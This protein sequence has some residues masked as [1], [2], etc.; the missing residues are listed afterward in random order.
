MVYKL[1]EKTP[2]AKYGASDVAEDAARL[3]LQGVSGAAAAVPGFFGDAM[4]FV[5]SVLDIPIEHGFGLKPIPYEET[6]IGKLLPTT[7]KHKK[8][9]EEGIP[10]LKP[11]N[12]VEKFANEAA[13]DA[14]QLFLPG[15]LLRQ[16]KYAFSPLR[17]LGISLSA[18]M[19][20]E[21]TYQ[22]T[23]NK[24]LAD[25]VKN[26]AMLAFSLFN[27]TGAKDIVKG[28]YSKAE[29]LRPASASVSTG[30]LNSN[31]SSVTNR[32]LNGRQYNQLAPS[33][34][35]V[36]DEVNKVLQ[37][38]S[39]GTVPVSTLQ[40]I[41]TSLN[42][43]LSNTLYEVKDRKTRQGIKSTAK[44]INRF[45]RETLEEYGKQNPEWWKVYSSADKAH[46]AVEQS[47]FI[48]RS[49]EKFMKGRPESIAHLF[50]IGIPAGL[51]WFNPVGG[52]V[53]A[54]G[55]L[56]AKLGTRI[57][58]S[59]DLAKHYAKVAGAAASDNPKLITKE[60]DD[61]EEALEKEKKSK[62]KLKPNK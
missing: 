40:S 30:N 52:L 20:G 8:N 44:S 36:I 41:K 4:N 27:P 32:I 56:A 50:G 11:K 29:S 9:L 10:Y 14:V 58:K 2:E 26:G 21:G 45:L 48:S 57:M 18:N 28:L 37:S 6:S 22:F 7:K 15:R 31:L 34:K 19:A 12:R 23:G 16:G 1:K 39:S 35:F 62:Y 42:E 46:G 59:K 49:L 25:Q 60:L 33:E 3:G 54:A 24:D 5:K 55:Y 13:S 17:S 53:S 43:V 38:T 51:S 61:L 47:N